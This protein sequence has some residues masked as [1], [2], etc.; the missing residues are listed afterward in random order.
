M[1]PPNPPPNYPRFTPYCQKDDSREIRDEVD[2]P[3]KGDHRAR[4]KQR[5]AGSWIGDQRVRPR[6]DAGRSKNIQSGRG[7][8]CYRF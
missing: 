7:I 8:R 4:W 5:G 3:T 2:P 6:E 1:V